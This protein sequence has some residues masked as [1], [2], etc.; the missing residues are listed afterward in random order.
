MKKKKEGVYIYD[1]Q[2]NDN[3]WISKAEFDNRFPTEISYTNYLIRQTNLYISN[4]EPN[5][6]EPLK[7]I[8]KSELLKLA[9]FIYDEPDREGIPLLEIGVKIYSINNK[10]KY[11][12]ETS[13]VACEKI[14]KHNPNIPC[15]PYPENIFWAKLKGV[16]PLQF[17]DPSFNAEVSVDDAIKFGIAE[18]FEIDATWA[19]YMLLSSGHE[20]QQQ[21]TTTAMPGSLS[22]KER[23]VAPHTNTI[24]GQLLK[25][26]KGDNPKNRNRIINDAEYERLFEYA[27]H[28]FGTWTLP[29]NIK[30]L[31]EVNLTK[32]EILYTFY[33][34][35][36][37]IRPKGQYPFDLFVFISKV[38]SKLQ[39][40]NL[41]DENYMQSYIYKKFRRKPSNYDSLNPL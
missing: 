31:L 29:R 33:L 10:I 22:D 14:K 39:D 5:K 6:A 9:Q 3:V 20:E 23:E 4:N 19:K 25:F 21:Q 13:K 32:D 34:L 35:F 12:I 1:G 30:P 24:V 16:K 2:I 38:F 40:T 7:E 18:K 28:Y 15:T 17:L 8:T 11:G 41:T 26:M 27:C 36:R 37:A